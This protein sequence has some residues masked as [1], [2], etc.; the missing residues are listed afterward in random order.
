MGCTHPTCAPAKS[1]HGSFCVQ[2]N[3]NHCMP[4][5]R[6]LVQLSSSPGWQTKTT[7]QQ[8]VKKFCVQSSRQKCSSR[9]P[10]THSVIS[11]D[12][13]RSSAPAELGQ[14]FFLLP[15]SG[16]GICIPQEFHSRAHHPTQ[17]GP[18]CR[19]QKHMRHVTYTAVTVDCPSRERVIF[20]EQSGAQPAPPGLGAMQQ[21]F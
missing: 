4:D 21:C 5:A 15:S 12:I 7:Q 10:Q 18:C 20:S 16:C 11:G 3:T 19:G 9:L 6:G 1:G 8:L 17:Q 2:T 14:E 13:S